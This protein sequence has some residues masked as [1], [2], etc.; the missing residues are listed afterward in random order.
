MQK[1]RRLQFHC[2]SCKEAIHFSIFEL[3][4]TEDP[5]ICSNCR[6]QYQFKDKILLRQCQ[7]FEALCQQILDSEEI[8]GNTSVGIDIGEHCVKI[9]YKLLLTRFNASLDLIVG[10]QPLSITFR[11]EPHVD[12]PKTIT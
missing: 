7:K 9:P 3:N 5:L 6:R 11:L 8:L 10:N 4:K 1:G 2:L 12:I